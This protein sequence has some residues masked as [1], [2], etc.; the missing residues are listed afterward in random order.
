M[1]HKMA[2]LIF[3]SVWKYRKINIFERMKIKNE[4]RNCGTSECRKK[5]TF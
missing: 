4:I 1:A 2:H 3:E 5:Y